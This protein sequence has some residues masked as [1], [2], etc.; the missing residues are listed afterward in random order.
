MSVKEH[1]CVKGKISSKSAN[2]LQIKSPCIQILR[3]SD[4]REK[5]KGMVPVC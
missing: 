2:I 4:Q 3:F 1:N 5:E